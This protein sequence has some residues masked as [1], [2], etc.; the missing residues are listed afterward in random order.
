MERNLLLGNGI[1]AHLCING[2]N[3]NDIANRFANSLIKSND[4]FELMFGVRFTPEICQELY[5]KTEKRG[6]ESLA[7]TVYDY[8]TGKISRICINDRM[9][10]LDAIICCAI[11]SIFYD[12]NRKLGDDYETRNLPDFS[13]FNHIYTLNYTE[14]WD[15]A[16]KCVYLHGKYDIASVKCNDKEVLHYSLERNMGYKGYKELVKKLENRFNMCELYTR[17]IIFSP[18]FYKK[19]EMM[20][21]GSYP[22]EHLY[23][24]E[25]LFLHNLKPLYADLVGINEIEVFGMSPYGDEEII[26][27]L[28]SMRKVIVY[29]YNYK[30]NEEKQ[31]W[32]RILTCYHEIKDSMDI[33]K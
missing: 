30:D 11:T 31:V 13:K 3:L 26:R 24:A 9:R 1:N 16:E 22:S 2:L 19:S 21:M 10:I 25:D 12:G 14:F 33:M 20:A 29:V 17:N 4:F 18:E 32:N 27:K 6:I 7:A 5:S 8:L 15:R 23:P 28:N